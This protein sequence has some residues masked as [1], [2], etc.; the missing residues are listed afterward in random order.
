MVWLIFISSYEKTK[1]LLRTNLLK[2][3]NQSIAPFL[4][5]WRI[6]R[7]LL[8]KRYEHYEKVNFYAMPIGG[9]HGLWANGQFVV[10]YDNNHN[11]FGFNESRKQRHLLDI[12]DDNQPNK[13]RV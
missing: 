13:Y 12:A 8:N 10:D 1:T 9:W 6:I 2:G 7:R 11:Y 4:F 5:Q 3:C